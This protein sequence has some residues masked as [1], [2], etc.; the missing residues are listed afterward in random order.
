MSSVPVPFRRPDC[1]GLVPGDPQDEIERNTGSAPLYFVDD[2]ECDWPAL[3]EIPLVCSDLEPW[4]FEL[5]KEAVE[6]KRTQARARHVELYGSDRR[7][8]QRFLD[9]VG[10][11]PAVSGSPLDFGGPAKS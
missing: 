10:A 9:R 2:D 3:L 8:F 1:Y 6:R 4:V 7:D 5:L 11:V